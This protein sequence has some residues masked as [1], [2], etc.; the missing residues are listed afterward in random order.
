MPS[1]G[2]E[3]FA[4]IIILVNQHCMVQ[5][6]MIRV[7][8]WGKGCRYFQWFQAVQNSTVHLQV[9]ESGAAHTVL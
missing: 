2:H 6:C 9:I 5:S 7:Y 3:V 4:I 1:D 8:L